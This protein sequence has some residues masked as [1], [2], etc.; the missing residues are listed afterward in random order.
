MENES[1]FNKWCWSDWISTC[2]RMKVDPY[3]LSA[4]MKLKYKWIK[5]L[6]IKLDTLN[7]IG[8]KVGNSPDCIGKG[9]SILNR[10]A[11]AVLRL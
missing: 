5:D 2:R 7:L 1:N 4:C 11:M 8:E 10:T 6:N 3:F 9:A